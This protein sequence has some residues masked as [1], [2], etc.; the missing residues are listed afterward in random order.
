M[1]KSIVPIAMAIVLWTPEASGQ[2]ILQNRDW[3]SKPFKAFL[4]PAGQAIPWLDLAAH[5]TSLKQD[6]P[7]GLLANG[8]PPFRLHFVPTDGQVSS[9]IPSVRRM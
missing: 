8:P 3:Q 1:M 6:L 7:I 4:P 9:N 5:A 2:T